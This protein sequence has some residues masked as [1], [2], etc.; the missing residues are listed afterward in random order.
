MITYLKELPGAVKLGAS[1]VGGFITAATTVVSLVWG[2]I[3][4]HEDRI[5]RLE[6]GNRVVVC[7]VQ[8]QINGT[9][10]QGCLFPNGD[11]DQ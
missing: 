8:A 6:D 5:R 4:D 7:W 10:P 11:G 2:P 1:F 9:D 3:Q